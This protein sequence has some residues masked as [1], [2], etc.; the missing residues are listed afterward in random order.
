[1]DGENNGK[2]YEE[3]DDVGGFNP[4]MFGNIDTT[5]MCLDLKEK[6]NCSSTWKSL[7]I[8][9]IW[10]KHRLKKMLFDRSSGD[11]ITRSANG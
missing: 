2:P 7:E 8:M 3:M 5:N 9:R 11:Y 10:D 6:K 4:P 1:M